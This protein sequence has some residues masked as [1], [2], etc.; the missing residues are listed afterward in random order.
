M[1]LETSLHCKPVIVFFCQSPK[2]LTLSGEKNKH[3]WGKNTSLKNLYTS[4]FFFFWRKFKMLSTQRAR[5]LEFFWTV[6]NIVLF[7]HS[8]FTAHFIAL[9]FPATFF[10]LAKTCLISLYWLCYDHFF[11]KL[12]VVWANNA[13]FSA[14]FFVIFKKNR[15]IGLRLVY[16]WAVTGDEDWRLHCILKS[17]WLFHVTLLILNDDIILL[18]NIFFE[19]YFAPIRTFKHTYIQYKHNTNT[20]QYLH[21]NTIHTIQ[22]NIQYKHTSNTYLHTP[23][24]HTNCESYK[25]Q[26]CIIIY[27]T[28]LHA[29]AI[30]ELSY[31]EQ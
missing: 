28:Q 17:R 1:C 14:K 29:T 3:F 6:D 12:A 15:N 16:R 27:I 26:Q 11:P 2:C 24:I 23:T 8:Y 10:G 22:T 25:E 30:N 9:N 19:I 13:N 21:Y 18:K 31:K 5:N 20:I 7:N 4:F